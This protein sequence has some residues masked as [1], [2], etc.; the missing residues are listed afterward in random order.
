[1]PLYKSFKPNSKTNIKIWKIVE[2]YEDLFVGVT[3]NEESITRVTKMKSELHQCGFLS[4]RHLLA[5]FGYTDQDLY[6][7]NNG[8]PH[9][10]DGKHISITHSF[11]FSAVVV[12][13]DVVGVDIERQREKIG[14]IAHKFIGYESK[15]LNNA[16]LEYIRK[17][18]IIW[19]IKES[20]YKLFATSGLS[21][22]RHTL[23][24]PFSIEDGKTIS[25]IDYKNIKHRYVAEYFEFEGFT[26]AFT[27]AA[28]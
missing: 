22:L 14:V 23:V 2:S 26:C 24:I 10:K 12:S 15:Y 13:D 19:C 18:T 20:L 7:D 27:L 5:E 6:Y 17:L 28:S 16:D 3:L 21:F 8:K 4:V 9:L 11:T 1:M 25:W